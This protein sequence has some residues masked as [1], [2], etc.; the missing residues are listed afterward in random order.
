MAEDVI[1][2]LEFLNMC[3][4]IDSFCFQLHDRDNIHI[5][6]KLIKNSAYLNFGA[7]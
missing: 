5:Q 3:N 4:I 6:A 1:K 2:A 7:S